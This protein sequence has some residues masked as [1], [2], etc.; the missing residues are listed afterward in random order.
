MSI[1]IIIIIIII[2][3]SYCLMKYYQLIGKLFWKNIMQTFYK[4]SWDIVEC[5]SFDD[6]VSKTLPNKY[7]SLYTFYPTIEKCYQNVM[8]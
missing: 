4:H 7:I 2:T 8:C 6:D 1:I 5:F 3:V